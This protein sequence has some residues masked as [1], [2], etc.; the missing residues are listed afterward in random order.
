MRTLLF[1]C[2][3]GMLVAAPA[4]AQYPPVY[5]EA[6]IVLPPPIYSAPYVVQTQPAETV[7]RRTVIGTSQANY[8]PGN[9]NPPRRRDPGELVPV[10]PAPPPS[11]PGTPP[12]QP[13]PLPQPRPTPQ[14]NCCDELIARLKALEAKVDN[15]KVTAEL[16]PGSVDA[17][18]IAV[19]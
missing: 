19:A 14:P 7:I 3:L 4:A 18:A 16:Y 5:Y 8:N 17:V 11:R 6:P 2:L 10:L 1:A 9:Y 12:P 15:I 13:N